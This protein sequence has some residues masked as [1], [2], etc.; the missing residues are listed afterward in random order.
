MKVLLTG[1]SSFTGFWFA[2]QLVASGHEV[3]ACFRG[4][5][6][7]YE[8]GRRLRVE[9]LHGVVRPVWEV[10]VGDSAFLSIVQSE[11]FDLFCHHAAEMTDY[12]SWDF[13][14][15]DATA[16]NT[17]SKRAILQALHER[18]CQRIVMTGSV[19]EPFEGVGDADQRSF[20][21]YGLSKHIS[22]EIF[23]M[24]AE[25]IGMKIDKFV[26]PNPFGPFEEPRFTSYLAKEWQAGRTP[27]CRTPAYV[28]DNIPVDLLAHAYR[29]FCE[30]PLAF[31]GN[32]RATPSGYVESQGDF[33]LRVAR[34]YGNRAGRTVEVSL[35]DQEDFS[36]P[37]IRINSRS[38]LEEFPEWDEENFWNSTFEYWCKFS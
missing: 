17:R 27:G 30:K 20:N 8:G 23:R 10:E 21:P 36:E 7:S 9:E 2:R 4:S 3:V 37:L 32:S 31:C 11:Q 1:A 33:S 35:A 38:A 24:E 16:K 22:Y 26:I 19:F 15:L 34:E 14:I 12:R 25:R 13:D 5:Q 18:G 28:R 6:D 29:A